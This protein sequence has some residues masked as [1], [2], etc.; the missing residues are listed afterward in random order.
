M[1]GDPASAIWCKHASNNIEVENHG[2]ASSIFRQ[3]SLPTVWDQ[4]M[5]CKYAR[6]SERGI[7][8]LLIPEQIESNIERE[9]VIAPKA[10]RYHTIVE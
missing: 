3:V 10:T 4:R 1:Q 8:P 9:Y 2:V 5:I 6:N 7:R